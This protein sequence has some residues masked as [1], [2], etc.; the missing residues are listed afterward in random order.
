MA[1]V[2]AEFSGGHMPDPFEIDLTV[3]THLLNNYANELS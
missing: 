3:T 1:L 2:E